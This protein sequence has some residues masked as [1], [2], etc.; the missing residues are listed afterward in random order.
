MAL[1]VARRRT[2]PVQTLE[3]AANQEEM[4]ALPNTSTHSFDA[5]D[6]VDP[7]KSGL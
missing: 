7:F 6:T 1:T 2:Q 3:H 4:D 5:I